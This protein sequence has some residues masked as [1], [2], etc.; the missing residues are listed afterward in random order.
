MVRSCCRRR[1]QS[2]VLLAHLNP[3]RIPQAPATCST[4]DCTTLRQRSRRQM[5]S[6]SSSV[7]SVWLRVVR[8]R[9]PEPE[10]NHRVGNGG[11]GR[12]DSRSES[13]QRSCPKG[14]DR[15]MPIRVNRTI[16]TRIFR[17][18]LRRS[19]IEDCC[20]LS[21]E[22]HR[23]CVEGLGSWFGGPVNLWHQGNAKN[24]CVLGR[25][26]HP[27][28]CRRIRDLELPDRA[29]LAARACSRCSNAAS[30]SNGSI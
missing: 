11:Q 5:P 29:R 18:Y 22:C 15:R 28:C 25:L 9:C 6:P 26:E 23:H 14:E 12:T 1:G 13:G 2:K 27:R 3:C 10:S 21:P 17:R 24:L 20:N 8:R 30:S 16:D 7:A 19:G 4:P